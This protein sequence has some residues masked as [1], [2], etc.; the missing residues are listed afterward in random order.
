MPEPGI[1]RLSLPKAVKPEGQG[2]RKAA[3]EP[4]RPTLFKGIAAFIGWLASSLAG[5]GAI[6][7]AIGYLITAAQLHLLGIA[8]LVT[9]G[10]EH[11]LQEGGNFFIAVGPEIL[12]IFLAFGAT[13]IV[14]SV[15]PA[16]ALYGAQRW[17]ASRHAALL[18][19]LSQAGRRWGWFARIAAYG[20][21][22]LILLFVCRL[23]L[24]PQS[25]GEPLT[26]SNLL[27]AAPEH[28]AMTPS[29]ER[30]R[31]LLIAGDRPRLDGIFSLRLYYDVLVACLLAMSWHLAANWRFPALA[32]APFAIVFL[33]YTI[34]LPMLY[35]VLKRQIQFPVVT[36][37]LSGEA[38]GTAASPLFLLSKGEQDFVLFRPLER[39]VVWLPRDQV[40]SLDVTGF[41]PILRSANG[42]VP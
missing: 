30:V 1:A 33:L 20:A 35:G 38:T 26:L 32:V 28:A 19:R 6:L 41:A 16:A 9:Y 18:G 7:Y 23:C 40:R 21:L 10:H 15:L 3:A 27:F 13:F 29:A 31:A 5:L 22:I 37:T 11:Y 42:A 39:K 8:P 2:H 25:F 24:D 36:L 17:T 12:L 14:F 34:L 4:G